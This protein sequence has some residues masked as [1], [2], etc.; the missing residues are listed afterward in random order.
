MQIRVSAY[1]QFDHFPKS[2]ID[3][4]SRF[5][6]GAF[7][8][9]FKKSKNGFPIIFSISYVALAGVNCE[10]RLWVLQ[11]FWSIFYRKMTG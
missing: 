7:W 6:L 5:F 9:V 2:K 3:I 11:S 10:D 8:S 4:E 1:F